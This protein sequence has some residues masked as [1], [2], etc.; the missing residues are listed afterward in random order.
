MPASICRRELEREALG[1]LPRLAAKGA[2]LSPAIS[3][4]GSVELDVAT[5]R[6]LC[7]GGQVG[8]RSG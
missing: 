7:A 4:A 6:S 8:A 1:K 2:T 3:H 5:Q